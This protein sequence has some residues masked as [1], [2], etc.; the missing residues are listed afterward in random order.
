MS[1][2]TSSRIATPEP[3]A[4]SA[5]RAPIREQHLRTDKWWRTPL[6]YVTVLTAFIIYST[7]AVFIGNHFTIPGRP[8]ISPFYSPCTADAC[9]P[10][11]TP[12]IG[13][14]F[15]GLFFL[16]R[17]V[18]L[19]SPLGFRLTCYYYRKAYYRSFYLSPP[20]CAV[21]E[22]HNRY[23]G[24]RRFPLVLQ[25]THRYWWYSAVL[26][27]TV[28]ATDAVLSYNWDGK[29]GMGLG[30]LVLTV[31]VLLIAG[32]TF[33]CHSCRHILG[34]RLNHFSKHKIRYWF[35][36]QVSKLNARHG[37]FAW[38]SLISVALADIYIRLASAGVF[39]DPRFF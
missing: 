22:P 30:S 9:G 2:Q 8:Y 11:R 26:V 14:M 13:H 37:F 18:F 20:A 33:G 7:Y 17:I 39:H 19:M 24:E 21:A 36:T 23:S 35:W 3:L 12:L 5:R 4:E 16:S 38:A 32:Y 31:N 6:I 27:L 25:N 28:L 29:F 34:G 1:T 10:A 15:G